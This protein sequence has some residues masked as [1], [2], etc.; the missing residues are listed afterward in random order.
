[1]SIILLAGFCFVV[2]VSSWSIT[3]MKTDEEQLLEVT[4]LATKKFIEDGYV[5]LYQWNYMTRIIRSIV[6]LLDLYILFRIKH[7]HYKL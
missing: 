6:S 2:F 7:L 3:K 1:M 5:T 4:Q